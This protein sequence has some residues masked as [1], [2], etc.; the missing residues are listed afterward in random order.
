MPELTP[1]YLASLPQ[2]QQTAVVGTRLHALVSATHPSAAGKVTGMLLGLGTAEALRLINS[3]CA[4]A[5]R[6][7]E[8]VEMLSPVKVRVRACVCV[9]VCAR[10]CVWVFAMLNAATV[11]ACVHASA[12]ACNCAWVCATLCP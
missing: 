12:C 1:A 8:A 3:P 11:R 6:V 9:C 2:A 4:L 5:D 10:V 7:R